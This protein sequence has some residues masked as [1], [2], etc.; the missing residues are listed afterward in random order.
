MLKINDIYKKLELSLPQSI[1]NGESRV[2]V[3]F[4]GGP[5]SRLL[6]DFLN[7]S[8]RNPKDNIIVAHINYLLRSEE[9]YSDENLVSEVCKNE[10]LILEKF[11][12]PINPRSKGVQEKAREIRLSIFGELSKKYK[13]PY[14]FLGHNFNDHTE[15]IFFNIIRG[16]GFKGLQGIKSQKRIVVDKHPMYLM[17]PLIE[18]SKNKIKI[19]CD[20]KNLKYNIDSSNNKNK[21]SRNKLRNKI[22]PEIEKINPN[23]LKSINSLS[24]IMNDKNNKKK[25][26]F[27][28]LKNL[29]L[30]DGIKILSNK[31]LEYMPN[32]FL[33]KIHYEMFEKILLEKS[34]SENLPKKIRLLRKGE[35]IFFEDYS[36]K[37]KIKKI[38]KKINIPG[39]TNIPDTGKIF[40]KLINNPFDLDNSDNNKIYINKKFLFEDL[41]ITSRYEG[42]RI[43]SMP[44]IYT[45]VKKVLSNEKKIENKQKILV[46]RSKEEVL[47]LVGIKQ[48]ISSYVKKNDSKVLEVSFLENPI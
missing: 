10:N 44:N 25:I 27:S 9:S 47:W 15:T 28:N 24:E 8:I 7:S 6:L 5:D 22:I 40:T 20:K 30:E 23:F 19:I 31:Y 35:N 37:N 48:S 26:K 14:I 45:R 2:I 17:R 43:N 32:T 34:Y 12:N 29:S 4:S 39:I 3:G 42:D 21:Y 18:L 41:R 16:T 46:L 38:N 13:T 33:G 1:I 36:K 11:N